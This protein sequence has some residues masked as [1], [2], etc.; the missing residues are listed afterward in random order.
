LL[1][2]Q[3]QG[4]ELDTIEQFG[5]PS[6]ARKAVG[7]GGLAAL[8]LDGVPANLMSVTGATGSRLLG[9]LTPGSSTNWARCLSWMAHHT[10]ALAAA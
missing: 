10:A 5:F 8:L 4:I 7:F 3:F 6:R 1:E 9:N 2:Q